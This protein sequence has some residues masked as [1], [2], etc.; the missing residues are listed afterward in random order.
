[1]TAIAQHE[2]LFF[3]IVTLFI[4]KLL[5]PLVAKRYVRATINSKLVS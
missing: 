5:R 2:I 1:M 4:N 3:A